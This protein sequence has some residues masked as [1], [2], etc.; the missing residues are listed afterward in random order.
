MQRRR[1]PP[2]VASADGDR[3]RRPWR[4]A[5]RRQYL[6]RQTRVGETDLLQLKSDSSVLSCYLMSRATPTILRPATR[7]SAA[8]AGA[9]VKLD[10]P[11]RID[12]Q[13]FEQF[14]LG[15]HRHARELRLDELS[16]VN[17]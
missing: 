1:A 7:S 8:P 10:R 9:L 16:Q 4:S 6:N 14:S 12:P 13:F 17:T 11:A 5:S 15:E 3:S 2:R